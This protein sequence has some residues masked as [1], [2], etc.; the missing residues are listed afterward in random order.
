MPDFEDFS[1]EYQDRVDDVLRSSHRNF[2]LRLRDWLD[3]LDG[4]SVS[5]P[6]IDTLTRGFDFAPWYAAG[7]ETVGSM[8]GSGRLEWSR[9][10]QERLAQYLGLA[11][12][13]ASDEDA[14][15]DFSS[16]FLW[17]GKRLDDNVSKI[18]NEI[19]TPFARDLLKHIEKSRLAADRA[20]ASDR[21]VPLDHNSS[22]V[23]KLNERL[24]EVETR[25]R[26]SNSLKLDD[27]YD[28]NL[29]EVGAARRLMSATKV[30]LSALEALL[31]P[32]LKWLGAKTAENALQI[33][34]TALLMLLASVLGMTIPG[35]G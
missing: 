2:S 25:M 11:R 10:R 15:A 12:H 13:L 27:E 23:A 31:V 5:K 19:I 35:L 9:D 34:V 24:E 21:L 30:R 1:S 16:Q 6:A 33:A 18:N 20:P 3:L 28:R 14:Y 7:A 17:A 8:V 26:E 32:A 22:G 29:A 4:S